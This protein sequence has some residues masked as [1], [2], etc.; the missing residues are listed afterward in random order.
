MRTRGQGTLEDEA[1]NELSLLLER[2]ATELPP[3]V[4]IIVLRPLPGVELARLA[5][6]HKA[7]REVLLI[8]RQQNPGPSFGG[9]RYGPPNIWNIEWMQYL[10]RLV[11]A[12]RFGDVA[13]LQEMI[14]AGVDEHGTP[15]LEAITTDNK[16]IVDAALCA[17]ANSGFIQ[18]VELLLDAGANVHSS[19][20]HDHPLV[21][22]S[23]QGHADV[24]ALL[25][26]RG[27]DVH[28]DN[29]SALVNASRMGHDNVVKLLIE[30]GADI[31]AQDDY[32]LRRA[33]SHGHTS[34]VA[35]LLQRGANV[36]A[37]GRE[38]PEL[39]SAIQL[40]S[41]REHA[42]VVQLLLLHGARLLPV[43]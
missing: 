8:L 17:A 34:T 22:A 43:A 30:L 2:V 37:V 18:A 25:I 6:V 19:V 10:C 24:V 20:H 29:D 28:A 26:E 15:L 14:T 38:D 21:Y 5:C 27:T 23:R 1:S 12:A 13:V 3:L 33:T 36:H 7:F 35:V 31:H 32:A 11:R 39:Y 42:E 40:A 9:P 41:L 16:R 4:L